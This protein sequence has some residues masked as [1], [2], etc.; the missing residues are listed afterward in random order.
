MRRVV[1]PNARKTQIITEE[2]SGE[3]LVYDLKHHRAHCL[4]GTASGVWR[5][6]DGKHSISEI[7]RLLHEQLGLPADESLVWITLEQLREAELIEAAAVQ[8]SAPLPSR[9][10]ISRR[11][12]TAAFAMPLVT[13]IVVPTA[14]MAQSAV[15]GGD[16]DTGKGKPDKP[17]KPDKPG[18]R[19]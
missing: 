13:S 11:L 9:R 8:P 10:E 14:A 15:V 6:C 18:K 17:D 5:Y 3:T 7:A 12:S 19:R 16:E 1:K 2:L 4:N